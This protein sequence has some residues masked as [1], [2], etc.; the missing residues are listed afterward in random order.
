MNFVSLNPRGEL[1][2]ILFECKHAARVALGVA[3]VE[4]NIALANTCNDIVSRSKGRFLIS[5]NHAFI[6]ASN[7]GNVLTL[8]P[9]WALNVT[10]PL[11]NLP[12][13]FWCSAS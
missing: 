1:V 2:R 12:E 9:A 3:H 4:R 11:F 8:R 7:A 5:V 10:F 6:H 13:F